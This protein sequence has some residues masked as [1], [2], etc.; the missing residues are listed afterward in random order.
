MG[1]FD[2][3]ISKMPEFTPGHSIMPQR[4]L[5]G[6]RQNCLVP[7][8]VSNL[9]LK[10]GETCFFVDRSY[11]VKITER[12]RHVR[13]SRGRSVPS[14]LFKGVR[15]YNNTCETEPIKESKTEYVKGYLY[16]TNKRILFIAKDQAIEQ[17][18]GTLLSVIPYSNGISLQF[19]THT[20]TFLLPRA[21][22]AVRVLHLLNA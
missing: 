11:Y 6:I 13:K 22:I 19:G 9:M 3:Q 21:E 5:D 10:K 1:L 14:I 17:K 8:N 2:Y 16:M 7:L 18:I 15:Y 4:A 20:F 12:T